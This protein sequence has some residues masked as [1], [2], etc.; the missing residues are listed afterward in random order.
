MSDSSSLSPVQRLFRLLAAERRDITYL[1][2][3]ATLAGVISLSL[4]L[5]VQSVIGFVSSG[6]VSTSLVVLIGFIVLGTALV[7]GLQIMQLHVVEYIQ[8]R[9]MARVALDFAVRLPRVRSEALEGEYLPEL[10]NRLLDVPTLQ[11][12][13]A[14]MLIEFS[15]AALQII[16]GL[17]LLSFY[18]P[19]FIAF[20][21]VLIGLLY[22]LIAVTGAKGLRTSIA[23]SKYKY[24]VLAWLEDVARTVGS[25]RLPARQGLAMSRTDDLLNDHLKARQSHFSVLITQSWGFV[26]FKTLVTAALLGIGC[27]LLIDKQLNIGQFVAAEI[28]II[29]TI[30]AVEKIIFKIDVVYDAL[31]ALDKIGH[32]LDVETVEPASGT[33]VLPGDLGTGATP[34]LAVD[35]RGLTYTYPHGKRAVLDQVSF[36]LAAGDH[37][38]LVGADGSGKTTLLRLLA[39]LLQGYT[40]QVAYGGLSLP[41]LSAD[42]LAA[43]VGDSLAHQHLFSGT[44]FENITL[45]QPHLT[46]ADAT[47]AVGLVGLRDDIYSRPDGLQTRVGPGYS[48]GTGATQK[49]LLARAIVGRPR[50]LLLDALLPAASLAERVRVLRRLVGADFPW[51]VI[52]GTTQPELLSLMPR[53]AVLSEGRLVADGPMAAVQDSPELRALLGGE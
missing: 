43:A 48:L 34:G 19:I 11:K 27:W 24:S 2:V 49:L 51:T 3:Y 17:I 40:G 16:F 44:V 28:V 35:V 47:W 1:Y 8:Q 39:G 20:G 21:L 50:L 26:L 36:A 42:A 31:T 52:L 45:N 13:L 37:L 9:L 46:V 14:T 12:G 33:A 25:F 7:G 18:H 32:V 6:A 38:A 23:E 5:G 30:S 15:S 29:L 41:D 10:M 22:A 4:P 53:V